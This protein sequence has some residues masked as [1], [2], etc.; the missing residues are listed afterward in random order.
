MALQ[1]RNAARAAVNSSR[2]GKA[3]AGSGRRGAAPTAVLGP[4]PARRGGAGPPLRKSVPPLPR[5]ARRPCRLI[6]CRSPAGQL[7]VSPAVS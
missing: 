6:G 7:P 4:M 1:G 5:R 3:T 2:R